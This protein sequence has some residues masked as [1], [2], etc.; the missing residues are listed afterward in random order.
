MQLEVAFHIEH[1][2]EDIEV[3][4]NILQSN[5][6]LQF[7]VQGYNSTYN[8]TT[9]NVRI[10]NNT[11]INYNTY[12]QFVRA[13]A[14]TSGMIVSNNLY[15]APNLF[16][17]PYETAIMRIDA[18]D[19]NGFSKID[20]NVWADADWQDWAGG[21][22]WVGTGTGNSGYRDKAEWLAYSQVSDDRFSDTTIDGSFRPA[23]G[24]VAATAGDR[25][26]GVM[27]DF[28]GKWRPNQDGR[29]VGAV[30]L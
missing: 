28:Y 3:R 25:A 1:G 19:L 20:N 18:N 13:W 15:Y 11:G 30:T 22:M 23:S 24:S 2:A 7:A 26:P 10:V 5:I 16:V 27:V 9:R 4:N 14:G 12:G 6:E 17:G 8:R 21:L 29:P